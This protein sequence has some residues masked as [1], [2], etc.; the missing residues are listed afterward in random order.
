VRVAEPARPA[1]ID[2]QS[3]VAR[4]PTG[5]AEGTGANG[6]SKDEN[7]QRDGNGN[8]DRNGN[9]TGN[10]TRVSG[11]DGETNGNGKANGGV[12]RRVLVTYARRGVL[13][14]DFALLQKV[15]DLFQAHQ[16]GADVLVLRIH[17]GN[18]PT[19]DLELP[20]LRFRYDY[21]LM[22]QLVQLLGEE[23]VRIDPI[24]ASAVG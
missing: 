12:A 13:Q 10:A 17:G 23:S 3:S 2:G 6:Q 24:A 18:G 9:R 20:S 8:G 21:H 16:G 19:V 4:A 15:H 1:S 7:G 5:A 11:R 14:E 22:R